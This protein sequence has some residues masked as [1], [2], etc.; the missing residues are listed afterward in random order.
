MVR[1]ADLNHGLELQC[2]L[3]VR[4]EVVVEVLDLEQARLTRCDSLSF[5]VV[6]GDLALWRLKPLRITIKPGRGPCRD[7]EHD[8]W[9]DDLADI[10][11]Q[12]ED[13]CR[14][15]DP[16]STEQILAESHGDSGN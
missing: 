7:V 12:L 13:M 16:Q 6:F 1:P 3:R 15:V 10:A 8:V 2:C 5:A 9:R 11:N 14:S 4:E